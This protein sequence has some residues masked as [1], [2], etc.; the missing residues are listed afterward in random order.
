MIKR[1]L[2]INFKSYILYTNIL[3]IMF[4]I[5][6]LVY[7]F[8]TTDDT[9]KTLDEMMKVFP[10]DLLKAFNM[11]ITSINTAYGWLK[12]EGF[13]FI[14]LI[15]GIYS[16]NLGYNIVSKEEYDKTIEYLS[17]LPIK[18]S[19]ILSNKILVSI[20]YILS[21]ILIVGIFNYIALKLNGNFNASEYLLLS[22]TPLFIAMPLFTINLLLAT[23]NKKP[24]KNFGLSLGLVFLFYILNVI[25]ELSDKV[26][27]IK[28]FSIYT[29]ADTRN[30]I[31]NMRINPLIVIISFLITIILIIIAY[32]KYQKKELI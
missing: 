24:K 1:E 16:S 30:I 12:S 27:F 32:L 31:T 17:F 23:I 26:N 20:I 13:M 9:L 4:F 25:S 28:Y 5:A 6:Y 15:I 8:I 22:I 14:L 3:I 29:L 11:D 10:K 21:M 7:P 19:K 18:R 2:K